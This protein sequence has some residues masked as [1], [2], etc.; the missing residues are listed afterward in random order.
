MNSHKT[1]IIATTLL[2]IT[3]SASAQDVVK[4]SHER[5]DNFVLVYAENQ[6]DK[7]YEYRF[8]FTLRNLKKV[9]GGELVRVKAGEKSPFIGFEIIDITKRWAYNY[10]YWYSPT[11]QMECLKQLLTN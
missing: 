8:E 1:S 6:T 9:E 3:I 7:A 10:K 11:I 4:T 5:A 2:F